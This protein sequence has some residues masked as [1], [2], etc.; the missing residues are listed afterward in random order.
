MIVFNKEPLLDGFNK[1]LYWMCLMKTFMIGFYE[2]VIYGP[3]L[4]GVLWRSF[5][6]TFMKNL[7]KIFCKGV[8]WRP[9]WR[10]L[11]RTFIGWVLWRPLWRP[12]WRTF[13]KNLYWMG[14][15]KTFM[16]NL[17]KIF[18]KGGFVKRC[19]KVS[20][21]MYCRTFGA[22]YKVYICKGLSTKVYTRNM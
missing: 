3:L 6:K 16:K 7:V 19:F 21:V 9:L 20:W 22:L 18:Y 10:P 12:L 11:W 1:Y 15:V 8:L 4:N 14:F 13:M 5:M 2:R 17:V